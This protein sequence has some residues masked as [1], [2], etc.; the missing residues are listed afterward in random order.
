MCT[1][2]TI[3]VSLNMFP[4][5]LQPFFLCNVKHTSLFTLSSLIS[6]HRCWLASFLDH[7]VKELQHGKGLF[8]D[9]WFTQIPFYSS[10][11]LVNIQQFLPLTYTFKNKIQWP[12]NL[13]VLTYGKW[14]ES[15][16]RRN[17]MV[18]G[19]MCKPKGNIKMGLLEP[20]VSSTS[21]CVTLSPLLFPPPL[22]WN[23][24]F[25]NRFP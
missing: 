10:D 22:A 5:F 25:K 8:S 20:W 21:R 18:L 1:I 19:G 2:W 24:M 15:P 14:R 12:I 23:W 3:L 9:W 16:S 6:L 7:G 17:P 11:S 13:S 4:C